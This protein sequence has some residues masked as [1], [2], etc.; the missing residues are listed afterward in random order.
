MINRNHNRVNING[1]SNNIVVNRK[2]I[3]NNQSLRIFTK[4]AVFIEGGVECKD[5]GVIASKIYIEGQLKVDTLHLSA[6]EIFK[7]KNA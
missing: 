6:Y 3:K 2:L 5:I 4:A 1:D 7:Q